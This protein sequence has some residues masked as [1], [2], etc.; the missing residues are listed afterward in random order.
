GIYTLKLFKEGSW[1]Y[2]HIDDQIP[3]HPS[4]APLFGK[5]KDPNQARQS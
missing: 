1:R 4:G 2:L 3:C 5:C